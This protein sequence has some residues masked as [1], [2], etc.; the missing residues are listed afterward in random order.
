MANPDSSWNVKVMTR[1]LDRSKIKPREWRFLEAFIENGG[2]AV[3]AAATARGYDLTDK[4]Q[5]NLA[6]RWAGDMMRKLRPTINEQLEAKGLT[7][8]FL[9]EVAKEG[10]QASRHT[11]K[12]EEVADHPTRHKFFESVNKLKGNFPNVGIDL[13]VNN[14]T[15]VV[16]VP[17]LATNEIE[18]LQAMEHFRAMVSEMKKATVDG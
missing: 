3:R 13:N 15:G 12:G 16:V 4:K 18:W 17:G 5:Y 11:L 14:K 1:P 6:A 8:N 9:A 7:D 2:N 10:I